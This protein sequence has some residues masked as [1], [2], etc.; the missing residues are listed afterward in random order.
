MKKN[1][2]LLFALILASQ[3]AYAEEE[4]SG[5][6]LFLDKLRMKI[7]QLV[8]QKKLTP[9][10]AVGGVRGAP[11]ETSDVYWKGE[12]R[13]IDPAELAAFQKALSLADGGNK[14]EAASAFA[15]F[16]KSYPDSPLRKDA[17]KATQLLQS[18]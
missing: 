3:A 17:D 13:A 4:K 6:G 14:K 9:T 18:P 11:V 12:A 5:L 8:P 16:A 2:A 15:D 10:T 1:V 7:E